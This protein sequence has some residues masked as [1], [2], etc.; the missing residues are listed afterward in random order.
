MEI[1]LLQSCEHREHNSSLSLSSVTGCQQQAD[2]SDTTSRSVLCWCNEGSFSATDN[3]LNALKNAP[4]HVGWTPMVAEVGARR[5][6]TFAEHFASR[7]SVVRWR[8]SELMGATTSTGKRHKL[9]FGP[10]IQ[11]DSRRTISIPRHGL[12]FKETRRDDF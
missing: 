7:L 10:R 4:G 9:P 3:F 1:Y 6:F 2:A 11:T 12:R 5:E 8:R